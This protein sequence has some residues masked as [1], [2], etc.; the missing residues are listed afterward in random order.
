[1]ALVQV[2]LLIIVCASA[3]VEAHQ[4]GSAMKELGV[5]HTSQLMAC[6]GLTARVR[7]VILQ[8]M[9]CEGRQV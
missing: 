8:A 2:D 5:I 6:S 3:A 1:M 4:S 9:L 7:P